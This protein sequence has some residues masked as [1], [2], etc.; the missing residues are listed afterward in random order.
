MTAVGSFA[1]GE[2]LTAAS[3]NEIGDMTTI[4]VTASNISATV[5]ARAYKMQD[6]VFMEIN[7]DITGAATGSVTF[8]LPAGY[9]IATT[10]IPIGDILM[11]DTSASTN[12]NGVA[13]RGATNLTVAPRIFDNG[14]TYTRFTR[15]AVVNATQPMTW[16]NGDTLKMFLVYRA[17]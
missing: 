14:A 1:V 13:I 15:T 3:L 12:Y 4:T 9:E 7:A 2:V 5:T 16:A 6:V 10:D 17:G 8:T 11:V